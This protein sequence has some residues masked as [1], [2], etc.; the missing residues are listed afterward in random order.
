MNSCKL[1]C[2]YWELNPGPLQEPVFLIAE[3]FFYILF[4]IYTVLGVH[5]CENKSED[6]PSLK[7]QRQII[8][9]LNLYLP[10]IA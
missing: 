6:H 9:L 5:S 10:L 7:S 1:P 8:K 4:P 2:G 3:P